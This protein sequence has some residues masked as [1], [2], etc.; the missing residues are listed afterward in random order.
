[1]AKII[2]IYAAA[3][4]TMMLKSVLLSCIVQ[5]L[6]S[7]TLQYCNTTDI[8][9][10]LPFCKKSIF[11]LYFFPEQKARESA[12]RGLKIVLSHQT[13]SG[14]SSVR[15][16][17]RYVFQVVL[18]KASNWSCLQFSLS[19][20]LEKTEFLKQLNAKK[21]EKKRDCTSWKDHIIMQY[22]K[23]VSSGYITV[24]LQ[25]CAAY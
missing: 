24:K 10:P 9:L 6:D 15:K 12:P 25:Q 3:I 11:F 20:E 13:C 19:I 17:A 1:M 4:S 18:Y 5:L 14:P 23:A 21:D 2:D 22:I 8:L 7:L 16:V